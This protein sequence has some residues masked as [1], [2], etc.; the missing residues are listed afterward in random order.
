MTSAGVTR[1]GRWTA[2]W[3]AGMRV[4]MEVMEINQ[5]P[6]AGGAGERMRTA[7]EALG[8]WYPGAFVRTAEGIERTTARWDERGVERKSQW[9][10]AKGEAGMV[11]VVR[12]R[13]KRGE[14]CVEV[15]V[16]K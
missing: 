7:A 12:R 11:D 2:A 10:M 9:R 8:E 13:R 15:M 1:W 16:A 14:D 6:I 4:G 5:Y 3:A